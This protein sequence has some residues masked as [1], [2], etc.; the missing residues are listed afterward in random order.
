MASLLAY[1]QENGELPAGCTYHLGKEAGLHCHGTPLIMRNHEPECGT[2]A[3]GKCLS[4]PKK[5]VHGLR[6]V[7]AVQSHPV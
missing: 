2:S 1:I 3:R 5:L 6:E 7:K 4:W